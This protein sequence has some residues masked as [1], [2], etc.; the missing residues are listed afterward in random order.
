MTHSQKHPALLAAAAI[1]DTVPNHRLRIRHAAPED[2]DAIGDT[3]AAAWNAAYTHIFDPAFLASAA[4]GR[5]DGWRQ[6]L[7]RLILAPNIVLVAER[8]GEVIGFAHASTEAAEPAVAE[9]HG[10]YVHPDAWGSDVAEALMTQ[11]CSALAANSG[12]VLWTLREAQRARRFYEKVGFRTT[13]RE[14][15]ESLSD[16][17]SGASVERPAVEYARTLAPQRITP[18]A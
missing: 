12:V 9:I 3:H 8:D 13:G 16:W 2:A 1:M 5:R 14:R 18:P 11:T 7:P 10:F 4:Q 6:T 17:T 15:A